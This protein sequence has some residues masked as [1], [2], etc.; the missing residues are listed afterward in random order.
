MAWI[1]VE[2][3][4]RRAFGWQ[5]GMLVEVGPLLSALLLAIVA[6]LVGGVYP[7]WRA[8]G[9]RPALAMREE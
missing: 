5:I 6:A 3:I 7:S 4:N 9:S 8:A 1:L 2:V